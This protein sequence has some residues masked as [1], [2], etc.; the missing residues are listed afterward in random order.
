[1]KDPTIREQVRRVFEEYRKGKTVPLDKSLS[2][3]RAKN[4]NK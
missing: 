2:K 3:I 4:M 1:M